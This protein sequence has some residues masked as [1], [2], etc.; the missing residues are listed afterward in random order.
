MGTTV[1][2]SISLL[3]FFDPVAPG[4]VLTFC[5]RPWMKMFVL[6]LY[7]CMQLNIN[8]LQA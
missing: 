8:V 4:H 3:L 6:L 2:V 5:V 1:R 7:Y